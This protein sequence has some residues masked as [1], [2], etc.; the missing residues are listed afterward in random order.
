MTWR[1]GPE[2]EYY[3]YVGLPVPAMDSGYC[4]GSKLAGPNCYFYNPARSAVMC[5]ILHASIVLT[6]LV[7]P[8]RTSSASLR[9]LRLPV[10]TGTGMKHDHDADFVSVLPLFWGAFKLGFGMFKLSRCL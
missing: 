8:T 5:L 2:H 7:R 6:L 3:D 4:G 1:P 10:S 9:L